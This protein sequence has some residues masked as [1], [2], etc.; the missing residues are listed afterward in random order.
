M[1][2]TFKDHQAHDYIQRIREDRAEYE[3]LKKEMILLFEDCEDPMEDN[4][5][6][7]D[8]QEVCTCAYISIDLSKLS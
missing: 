8:V 4:P 6:M 7:Q 3:K 1:V 2:G 5:L